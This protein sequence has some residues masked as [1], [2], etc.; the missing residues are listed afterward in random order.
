MRTTAQTGRNIS[1]LPT[2]G[3]SITFANF[4][5]FPVIVAQPNR[6]LLVAQPL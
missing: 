2:G 1:G 6:H 3:K 4:A 5:I